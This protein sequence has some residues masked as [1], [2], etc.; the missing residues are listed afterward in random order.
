M[1]ALPLR[2]GNNLPRFSWL[3]PLSSEK[4]HHR[5]CVPQCYPGGQCTSEGQKTPP[6]SSGQIVLEN[7][8]ITSFP[9]FQVF[10]GFIGLRHWESFDYR[11]NIVSCAKLDHPTSIQCTT[12]G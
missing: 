4:F 10:Q 12:D 5:G 3:P 11:R 8:P 7:N 1:L 9:G 6:G 2:N